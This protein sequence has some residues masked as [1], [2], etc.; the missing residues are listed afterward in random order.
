MGGEMKSGFVAYFRV[1]TDR[2]GKSRLGLEAQQEE[3]ER[4][5][6]LRNA[7]LLETYTEVESGKID[8]RPQ[9]DAAI[10]HCRR[11]KSTLIVAKLDRLSRNATFLLKFDDMV[12]RAGIN[13]YVCDQPHLDRFTLG[14]HALVAEREREMI[15]ERTKAALQAAKRRGVRLGTRN[16]RRLSEAGLNAIREN[17]D[18]HAKN[19]IAIIEQIRSAGANSL[20]QVSDA[21]NA[22]GVPTARGGEWHPEAVRRIENRKL[23]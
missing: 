17:A 10:K 15:S 14:I 3:I 18:A 8:Q 16:G 19:T 9:L 2:Q 12:K 11:T 22:R 1:S 7:D 4:Y 20:R 5:L 21:L 6:K 13:L 23:V